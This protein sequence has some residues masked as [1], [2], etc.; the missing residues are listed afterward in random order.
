MKDH[1]TWF[2]G[3]KLESE[4]DEKQKYD[5]YIELGHPRREAMLPHIASITYDVN[6]GWYFN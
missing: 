1:E 3:G 6:I 4:E 5:N 2:I